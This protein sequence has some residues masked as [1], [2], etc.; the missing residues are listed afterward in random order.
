MLIINRLIKISESGKKI[1]PSKRSSVLNYELSKL[2]Y[3][4][5]KY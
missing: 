4:L 3:N 5:A 2:N 1:K